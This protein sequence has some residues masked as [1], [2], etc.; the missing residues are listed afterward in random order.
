[1]SLSLSCDLRT[2]AGVF[3]K[4]RETQY[5]AEREVN[6]PGCWYCSW[7]VGSAMC[8]VVTS[9]AV[10]C[11]RSQSLCMYVRRAVQPYSVQVASQHTATTVEGLGSN[12]VKAKYRCTSELHGSLQIMFF[13]CNLYGFRGIQDGTTHH[14][15]IFVHIIFIKPIIVGWINYRMGLKQNVHNRVSAYRQSHSASCHQF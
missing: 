2:V 12:I 8:R 6:G 3:Y 4:K 13:Y 7:R 15:Q 9:L 10:W 14:P 1:M 11:G 5:R